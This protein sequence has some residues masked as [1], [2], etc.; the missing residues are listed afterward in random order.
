MKQWGFE[1]YLRSCKIAQLGQLTTVYNNVTMDG[2]KRDLATNKTS[3]DHHPL[4]G[5]QSGLESGQRRIKSKA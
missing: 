2:I 3:S 1:K 5:C 4:F